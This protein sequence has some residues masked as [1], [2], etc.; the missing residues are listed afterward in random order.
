MDLSEEVGAAVQVCSKTESVSSMRHSC[1][2]SISSLRNPQKVE[3]G[4]SLLHGLE[5]EEQHEKLGD[6]HPNF[7]HT[8]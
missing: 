1:S 4:K 3:H 8:L 2:P 5:A 6:H 7:K